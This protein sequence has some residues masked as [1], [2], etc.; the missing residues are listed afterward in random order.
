MDVNLVIQI[1][2]GVITGLLSILVKQM[3]GTMIGMQR[4][5][6]DLTALA[7]QYVPRDEIDARFKAVRDDYHL[8]R[9]L[10]GDLR[11][12]HEVLKMRMQSIDRREV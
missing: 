11:T 7:G 6:D 3:N 5:L 4:K 10:I 8:L 2:M 1:A 9:N 12:D